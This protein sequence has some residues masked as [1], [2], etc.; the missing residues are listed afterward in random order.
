MRVPTRILVRKAAE[1]YS[2]YQDA[3]VT[4]TRE[5]ASTP[6]VQQTFEKML[7]NFPDHALVEQDTNSSFGEFQISFHKQHLSVQQAG[8]LLFEEQLP[9]AFYMH[10]LQVGRFQIHG[11]DLLLFITKSRATTG[12]YFIGLYSVTGQRLLTKTISV[13]ELWDCKES[14]DELVFLCPT[15]R[16]RTIIQ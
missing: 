2:G 5:A 6:D 3:S 14:P 11:R 10:E 13:G 7:D 15:Q 4:L 16:L 8:R 1:N 12:L 9:A